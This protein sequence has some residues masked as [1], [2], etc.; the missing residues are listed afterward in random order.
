MLPG[1]CKILHNCVVS[2]SR[3]FREMSAPAASP[4]LLYPIIIQ[5]K[6]IMAIY[7]INLKEGDMIA[8]FA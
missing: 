4:E 8:A 1:S 3:R 5:I 7:E 6:S 2:N